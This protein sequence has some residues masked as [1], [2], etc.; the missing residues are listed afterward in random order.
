M[1]SERKMKRERQGGR[2]K[3]REGER[4]QLIPDWRI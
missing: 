3:K 2:R 4:D 1:K